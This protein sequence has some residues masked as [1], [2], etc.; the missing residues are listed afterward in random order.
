[1]SE[2]Y[3]LKLSSDEIKEIKRKTHLSREK[4][5]EAFDIFAVRTL[6]SIKFHVSIF[7][8]VAIFI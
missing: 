8:Y 6:L 2:K 7:T 3:K 5:T 1:M 4:I